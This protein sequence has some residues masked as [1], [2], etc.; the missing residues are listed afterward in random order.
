MIIS[1]L[2]ANKCI[3]LPSALFT[4]LNGPYICFNNIVLHCIV[5]HDVNLSI[6]PRDR[7]MLA[8]FTK[9]FSIKTSPINILCYMITIIILQIV[10]NSNNNHNITNYAT[11]NRSVSTNDQLNS[12]TNHLIKDGD[13][14][15]SE[16]A[17]L[18]CTSAAFP[19]I[20]IQKSNN[21]KMNK[22]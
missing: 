16:I 2:E 11:N 6:S 7:P 8:E 5:F 17:P 13:L 12:K 10:N 1:G 19:Q 15:N 21:G 20:L 4:K 14:P 22:L 18:I 3:C 9:G